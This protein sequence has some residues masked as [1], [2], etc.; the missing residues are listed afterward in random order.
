[1]WTSLCSKEH[2]FLTSR[3][4]TPEKLML[5]HQLPRALPGTKFYPK[6]LKSWRCTHQGNCRREG[7]A[8]A[9]QLGQ[10][11]RMD[12]PHLQ[13]QDRFSSGVLILC[14]AIRHH[15]APVS[16]QNQ[17]CLGSLK[18]PCKRQHLGTKPIKSFTSTW[19]LMAC[20]PPFIM[21]W[22]E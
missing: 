6:G 17:G 10:H 22:K 1:M 16:T 5:C 7:T 14:Y 4:L 12:G 9:H 11:S 13:K 15:A 20:F 19:L 18:T 21:P 2:G 3:H 8:S